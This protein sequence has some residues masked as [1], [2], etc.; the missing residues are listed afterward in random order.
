MSPYF[1]PPYTC[2]VR[3]PD[4]SLPS[5]SFEPAI[6]CIPTYARQKLCLF[7]FTT[8]LTYQNVYKYPLLFIIRQAMIK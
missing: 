4:L 6:L 2:M 3:T 1:Q 8:L 7:D 5:P